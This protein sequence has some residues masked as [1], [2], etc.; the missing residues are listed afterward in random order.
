[1]SPQDLAEFMSV[2]NFTQK[3]MAY[4]TGKSQ[5]MVQFWLIGKHPIPQTVFMLCAALSDEL[6]D[7]D[8]VVKTVAEFQG[9]D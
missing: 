9:E 7:V 4:M 1:M 8:W 2:Q 5:R 3:D 6:V